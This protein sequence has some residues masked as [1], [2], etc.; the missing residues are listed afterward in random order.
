VWA[1]SAVSVDPVALAEIGPPLSQPKADSVTGRTTPYTAAEH[2]IRTG[3]P[4][5]V[6][7]AARAV[8]HSPGAKPA[9]GSRLPGKAEN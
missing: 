1:A 3:L 2:P 6:L 9:P 4:Q 7:V 5:I 8:I